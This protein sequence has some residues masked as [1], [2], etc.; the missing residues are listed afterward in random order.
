MP[1]HYTQ[2]HGGGKACVYK[3]R[4]YDEVFSCLKNSKGIEIQ[5]IPFGTLNVIQRLAHSF[6][7]GR[8]EPLRPEHLNDEEVDELMEKLP[9][10]ILDVLLPFQVDGLRFGLRRGG[11][12][13]IADEM[14]LGKT[15]QVVLMII[16]Q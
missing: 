13:L 4:E 11:R 9:R 12:C 5:K 15:L 16:S 2:N 8:W 10:K 14:G 6:E 7:T 1:S 3:L